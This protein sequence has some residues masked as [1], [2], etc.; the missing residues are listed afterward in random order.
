MRQWGMRYM[1]SKAALH[2]WQ[3]DHLDVVTA[4]L[5]P[6][7][8]SDVY[9]QLPTESNWLDPDLAQRT[10]YVKLLKA[11]YGLKQAPKLWHDEIPRFRNLARRPKG[12][13][14]RLIHPRTREPGKRWSSTSLMNQSSV[15]PSALSLILSDLVRPRIQGLQPSFCHGSRST[16]TNLYLK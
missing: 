2:G 10:P 4:F 15:C 7:L 14:S 16:Y 13:T 12:S 3:I 5:N 1:L 6:A 11:L 8:D 9:M